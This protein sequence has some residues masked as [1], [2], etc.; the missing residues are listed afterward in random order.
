MI[1]KC[2]GQRIKELREL[3]NYTR[4]ELAEENVKKRHG[5]L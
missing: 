1:D 3:R 2:L 5:R 4:E